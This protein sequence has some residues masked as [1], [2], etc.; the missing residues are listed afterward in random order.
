MKNCF[1]LKF[2]HFEK[3]GIRQSGLSMTGR[4]SAVKQIYLILFDLEREKRVSSFN[5]GVEV[6][7]TGLH[8]R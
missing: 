1:P 2:C 7:Q 8:H 5:E 3:V 6:L 4:N